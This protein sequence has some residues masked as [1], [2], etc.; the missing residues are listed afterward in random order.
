[1][2]GGTELTRAKGEGPIWPDF[3]VSPWMTRIA[4]GKFLFWPTHV[5]DIFLFP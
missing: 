2:K 3:I 1:M 5:F 4:A